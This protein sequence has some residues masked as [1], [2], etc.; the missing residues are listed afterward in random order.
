MNEHLA[1]SSRFW[2]VA[3]ANSPM[4]KLLGDRRFDAE[5]EDSSREQ[6]ED[7]VIETI[8]TGSSPRRR[9][10]PGRTRAERPH[11]PPRVTILGSRGIVG[12]LAAA[13]RRVHMVEPD[14]PACTSRHSFRRCRNSVPPPTGAGVG[15]RR[16]REGGLQFD[17]ALRRHRRAVRQWK[18]ATSAS[19][20]RRCSPKQARL[21]VERERE[22]LHRSH[23]PTSGTI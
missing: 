13:P 6:A 7:E 9:P 8:A 10:S 20:S 11:H 23:C 17:Q 16:R 1:D 21:R 14:A 15:V 5:V 12:N 18:D 4:G 19:P 3:M 2:D 22:P